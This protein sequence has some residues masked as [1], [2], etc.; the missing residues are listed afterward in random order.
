[1]TSPR[2]N[3]VAATNSR[4]LSSLGEQ[5]SAAEW[6]TGENG[7][8]APADADTSAFEVA[9][10]DRAGPTRACG[11]GRWQCRI[12]CHRRDRSLRCRPHRTCE[13]M[14]VGP[15][16]GF[17]SG[18]TRWLLLADAA[19][20]LQR[21]GAG[22]QGAVDDQAPAGLDPAARSACAAAAADPNPTSKCRRRRWSGGRL[23]SRGPTRAG[24]ERLC[25]FLADVERV[26]GRLCL[27]W[28]R[29]LDG[30]PIG[31]AWQPRRAARRREHQPRSIRALACHT[32]SNAAANSS[33]NT[34]SDPVSGCCPP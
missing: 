25:E 26:G 14:L 22:D 34:Y 32:V 21:I 33:H 4:P 29:N 16:F 28:Q 1:M 20:G 18:S 15:N 17:V 30:R 31:I 9:I 13:Q 19:P 27:G 5:A 12:P 2:R 11:A 7:D 23:R 3:W 8:A 10:P 6:R 24:A